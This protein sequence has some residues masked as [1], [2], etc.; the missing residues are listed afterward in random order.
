MIARRLT[1]KEKD[2]IVESYRA[3]ENAN[4]LA[5]KYGCSSHTINRTVKAFLSDGEYCSLKE[6]RSK[7][8]SQKSE[9][10][11]NSS[12]DNNKDDLKHL[13]K[14]NSN[15]ERINNEDKSIKLD[16]DFYNIDVDNIENLALEDADDFDNYI[17]SDALD[18]EKINQVFDSNFEE[19]V[20]LVSNFD[21]DLENQKL[22]FEIHNYES[23]PET[24]Y[25]IVDK[26]VELDKQSI[27]D[28]PE[29]GFLPDNELKRYAILLFSNQRSAKRNC[30][31]NQRV[32]KIPN[33]NVFKVSK[34]YL[35][36]KGITR[37]I[38]DDLIIG[39]DN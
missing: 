24:V 28:L 11:K 15:L 1:K 36:S 8:I 6:K 32:I 7:V 10:S 21:F 5:S 29:W 17:S 26:K 2:E 4:V 16:Q 18:K 31:R 39:L 25:M 9:F 12:I 33:T 34:S 20:P 23:L 19:I 37:L 14:I 38:L 27:S 35:L 13:D 30:S 3:G 22:D